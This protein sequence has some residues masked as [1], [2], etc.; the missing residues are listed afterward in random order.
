MLTINTNYK[1]FNIDAYYKAYDICVCRIYNLAVIPLPGG[2]TFN[3]KKKEKGTKG[4]GEKKRNMSKRE[5]KY[6]NFVSRPKKI[7]LLVT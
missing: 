1:F 2:K 6:P 5:G 3:A 7:P 4:I